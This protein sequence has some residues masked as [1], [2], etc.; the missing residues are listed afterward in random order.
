MEPADKSVLEWTPSGPQ[1][2]MQDSKVQSKINSMVGKT[3]IVIP[4]EL[5]KMQNNPE[6]ANKLWNV[7]II[8]LQS[9]IEQKQNQGLSN[10]LDKNGE[11]NHA[12]VVSEGRITVSSSSEFVEARKAREAKHAEWG[13]ACREKCL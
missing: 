4:P 11:I 2:S 10:N 3:S 12:C 5:K 7:L 13:K 1:P 6:L 8:L 9:I